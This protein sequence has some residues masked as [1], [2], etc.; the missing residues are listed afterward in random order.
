MY[1]RNYY[2]KYFLIFNTILLI[3]ILLYYYYFTATLFFLQK[4]LFIRFFA[5]RKSHHLTAETDNTAK[6][7]IR[8]KTVMQAEFPELSPNTK[9][10]EPAY[11]A[12]SR[13]F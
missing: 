7:K 8:G 5:K 2:Y 6:G 10:R 12:D 4:N 11:C 9:I 13:L 3:L 1:S